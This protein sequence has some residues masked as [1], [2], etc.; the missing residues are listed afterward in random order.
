MA[1]WHDKRE[2]NIGRFFLLYI[3]AER[4]EQEQIKLIL[5]IQYLFKFNIK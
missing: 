4:I 2:E 5:L 1:A 3:L